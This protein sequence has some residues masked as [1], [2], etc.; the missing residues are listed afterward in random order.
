MRPSLSA[1]LVSLATVASIVIA[2]AAQAGRRPLT[3]ATDTTKY[4]PANSATADFMDI[5]IWI[6]GKWSVDTDE[7]GV[8]FHRKSEKPATVTVQ[9]VPLDTCQYQVIRQKLIK[10]WGTSAVTQEQMRIEVMQLGTSKYRGYK[11]V[12]PADAGKEKHWCYPQDSKTAVEVS[13]PAAD[14]SLVKFVDGNLILQLA[15]RRARN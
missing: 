6:P 10:L 12:A 7:S 9:Q 8:T 4:D 13:A 14:A 15:I 1:A 3:S 5:R 11:W 2:P